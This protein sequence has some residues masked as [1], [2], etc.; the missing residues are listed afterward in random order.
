MPIPDSIK[1]KNKKLPDEPGVYFYYDSKG[2]LLYIGKATSLKK[3]VGSY[4]TKA[5]EQR[6]ERLVSEITCIDYIETPTVIE[7]LVLEANQIKKYEPPYNIL[8][9][10]D[11]SFL[12]LVIT[13][14]DFPKPVLM[15]GLELERLGVDPFSTK[16]SKKAEQ[17]FLRV[18]GPYTSGRNLRTA[19]ELVRKII[20]WSTCEPPSVSG[21]N[22]ACFNYHIRRCPGVCTGAISKTEYRKI[23]RQ[24]IL[25]FE[26]KKGQLLKQMVRDMKKASKELRFEDA[27]DIK[28]NIFALEHIQDIAL[29][30]SD[31]NRRGPLTPPESESYINVMGRIEGYDISNISGTSAVGS[32]VVFE[33]G[34]PAKGEYRKF[35]IKG[36]LPMSFRT[37]SRK[38]PLKGIRNLGDVAMLEEMIR[39]RLARAEKMHKAW[40]LPEIMIIDGGKGQVNIVRL[41]LDELGLDIP[42][43][44]LAKGFDRKQDRL[45]YNSADLELGRVASNNKELFQRVRDESH[46]FA[47]KYHR[48]VRS[49]RSGVRK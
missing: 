20:P 13:N 29:V 43:I 18:F 37:S 11:K 5:H 23:I 32:M 15:R 47:I 6:T 46:R 27:Q 26:G 21:R 39:R 31:F 7:A 8:M 16:M 28:R 19:L 41:I 2:K 49:R 48:V 9:R 12:Y 25:F 30:T 3:R 40:P 44:G 33:E 22:K 4:F 42:V 38:K 45:V 36:M 34:K 1:I 24:L 17:K 14:E 10:D 35:K